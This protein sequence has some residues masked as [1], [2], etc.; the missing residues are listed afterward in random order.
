MR[1]SSPLNYREK[2]ETYSDYIENY[3]QDLA[4][5]IY[6][7][8]YNVIQAAWVQDDDGIRYVGGFQS[9]GG[10]EFYIHFKIFF[11]K[12]KNKVLVVILKGNQQQVFIN[13]Y[14]PQNLWKSKIVNVVKKCL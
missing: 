11:S 13:N 10:L 12:S 6:L 5:Q 9:S 4:H 1:S 14:L 3:W 2:V 8:G 7:A